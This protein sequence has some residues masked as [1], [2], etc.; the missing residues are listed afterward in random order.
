MLPYDPIPWLLEQRGLP[1]LRARRLLDIDL[2]GDMHEARRLARELTA[3]QA[4]DGSFEHSLMKTAGVLNLLDDLRAP[5]CGPTVA[6]AATYLISVLESQPGHA[7]ARQVEPGSLTAPCDLGGFFGPYEHRGQPAAMA[8]G[9]REMN[10]YREYEPLLGPRTP[11]RAER[12]SSLDRP[13][14]P[15]CYSWGLIP[16]SYTVEALCRAGHAG[17]PRLAPAVNALL[18]A[19]RRSGGWCRNLGGHPACTSHALRWMG[20]HPELR[21]SEYAAR[22]VEFVGRHLGG[23]SAIASLPAVA[24]FPLKAARTILTRVLA[25][26]V[27]RQRKNGSFGTPHAVEKVAAVLVA[28]RALTPPPGEPTHDETRRG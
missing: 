15:S 18:G 24:A 14:P 13:G 23:P 19:Q 12:R 28:V 11:V 22:A 7:R 1:A 5:D 10:H 6:R 20:A 17:D 21:E 26:L 25:E 3:A 8:D 16:L 9:A 27:P 4:E 2:E